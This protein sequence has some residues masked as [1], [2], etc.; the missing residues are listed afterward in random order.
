MLKFFF[1]VCIAFS[2]FRVPYASAHAPHQVSSPGSEDDQN[3]VPVPDLSEK[4]VRYY[5]SGNVLWVVNQV[6]ALLI[7]I[8]FLFT[9]FSASIRS[10]AQRLG[11][12]WFFVIGLYLLQTEIRWG[13]T[14]TVQQPE[15][16]ACLGWK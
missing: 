9:G 6:W 12:R 5:E 15:S 14:H 2:L 16:H 4:A 11:R 7:P 1:T 8:L 10:W 3:P 13:F